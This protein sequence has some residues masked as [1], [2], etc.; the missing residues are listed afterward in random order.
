VRFVRAGA[1]EKQSMSLQLQAKA[2]PNRI[3]YRIMPS[4]T[5][6][7]FRE[8]NER[9][10]QVAHL[11]RSLGLRRGDVIAVLME[12]NIEYFEIAWAANRSGLYFTCI[13]TRLGPTEI[14]YIVQDSGAKVVFTSISLA[15]LAAQA[16][17]RVSG[18]VAFTVGGE[19]AMFQAYERARSAFPITP[20][21]DQ[22]P[23]SPMLYSSGTT[24]RPKGV[25]FA[26]PANSLDDRD[27]L[28]E[29]LVAQ[30]GLTG[31][32]RYLSPAPLYHA[33]PLRWSMSV[34]SLGGTVF[35]MENFDAEYSLKLIDELKITHSQWVP[36]HFIRM[37]KLP[38]HVRNQYDLSSLRMA[39]HAA[40]PCPVSVKKEMLQ[41]W[42]PVI[43]EFYAGTEFNGFTAIGPN[44]WLEH[45]GS[46]GRAKSGII[47]ICGDDGTELGCGQ[48]GLIYFE[49]GNQ[50]SYHNDPMKTAEAYNER[51]WSTLGDIGWLDAAGY[52]YLTDR[53]SFMIICGGVNIYPQEI[54]NVMIGHPRVA[55]VA[56]IGA[57][58]EEMGERIVAV[59]QL[60][61]PNDASDSLVNEL[62]QL[63]SDSLSKFK[64]PRQVD[65][66]A[67]L[68]RHPTGKLY[69]RMLRDQ[70]RALGFGK[71]L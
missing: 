38:A 54:E 36:T 52:L 9:S 7:S 16:L 34:Q 57:P 25:R 30:F 46:V 37:L 31:N 60:L 33:A 44:E 24:G 69:K 21:T 20:I 71:S 15:D 58:D 65:F 29:F 10:N 13:S 8:L 18:F 53:K 26:L 6:V 59:V 48:E 68:P 42:G 1:V 51:G 35:V 63:V 56:V 62:Q 2:N 27:A 12:N 55:D 41:W 70:Y 5:G 32:I 50:F 45:P 22:S 40:A 39:V 28:T 19:T 64:S 67:E 47:H 43:H 66:V 14:A 49:G 4:G 11:L 23:G 17:S 61:D 3:A